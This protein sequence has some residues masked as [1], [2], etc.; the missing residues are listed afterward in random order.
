MWGSTACRRR[1]AAA[2]LLALVACATLATLV[3]A[4]IPS[5]VVDRCI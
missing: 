4:A 5:N 3:A 1:P 2:A